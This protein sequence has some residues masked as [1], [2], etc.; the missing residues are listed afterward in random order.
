MLPRGGVGRRAMG[1]KLGGQRQDGQ[2]EPAWD[3][4]GSPGGGAVRRGLGAGGGCRYSQ[5]CRVPHALKSLPR[6]PDK[7]RIQT[8]VACESIQ[9]SVALRKGCT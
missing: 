6:P 3:M 1:I 9:T 2:M 5:I 7:A 8:S 4:E